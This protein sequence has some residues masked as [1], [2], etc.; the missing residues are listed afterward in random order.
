MFWY[1]KHSVLVLFACAYLENSLAFA[2]GTLPIELWKQIYQ[3]L[4]TKTQKELSLL[5]WQWNRAIANWTYSLRLRLMR[6]SSEFSLDHFSHLKKLSLHTIKPLEMAQIHSLFQ[7]TQLS[8]LKLTCYL[9]CHPDRMLNELSSLVGLKKIDLSEPSCSVSDE[10][11]NFVTAL[12]QLESLSCSKARTSTLKFL[13][14]QTSLKHLALPYSRFIYPFTLE[15]LSHLKSLALEWCSFESNMGDQLSKLTNL[16]F[17]DLSN[18]QYKDSGQ[19]G[20]SIAKLRQL[21]DLNISAHGLRG[22]LSS[23]DLIHLSNLSC[24]KYLSLIARDISPEVLCQLRE[25]T[26]LEV[27]QLGRCTSFPEDGICYLSLLTNLKELDLSYCEKKIKNSLST[28]SNLTRLRHLRLS[29]CSS[30]PPQEW[31][32]LSTLSSLTYLDLQHCPLLFSKGLKH[33]STLINLKHFILERCMVASKELHYLSQLTRLETL[34]L[35]GSELAL[36]KDLAFLSALRGLKILSLE[37]ELKDFSESEHLSQLHHLL[38]LKHLTFVKTGS[39]MRTIID[40]YL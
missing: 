31:R 4:P 25:L 1:L 2:S 16:S 35:T 22:I 12:T 21:T 8:K 28:L 32:Y 17:L 39:H 18:C 9:V 33:V 3:E 14:K 34:R 37:T 5:N 29:G 10:M 38:N 13:S 20:E 15:N 19:W 26:A 36:P 11:L 30:L 27:L 6:N 23:A 7:L 24:L 40:P